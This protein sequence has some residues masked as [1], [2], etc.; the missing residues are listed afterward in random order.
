MLVVRVEIWPGGEEDRAF[1]VGR[2]FAASAR[3]FGGV[4]DYAVVVESDNVQHAALVEGHTR[5]DGFWPLVARI[6]SQGESPQRTPSRPLPA[7]IEA[8]VVEVK[9]VMRE[10]A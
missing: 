1:E 10:R 5:T 7:A 3:S 8:M 9:E 4:A 6:A 2:A